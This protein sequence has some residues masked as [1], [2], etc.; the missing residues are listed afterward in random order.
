MKQLRWFAFI[1]ILCSGCTTTYSPSKD[2]PASLRIHGERRGAFDWDA[3]SLLTIDQKPV[4]MT[5]SASS[6]RKIDAGQHRL[7]LHYEGNRQLFGYHLSAPPIVVI[8]NFELGKKYDLKGEFKDT[9]VTVFVVDAG[10]GSLVSERVSAPV[11]YYS[12]V[13]PTPIVVP[14]QTR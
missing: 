5:W 6:P 2:N 7:V 9:E 13:S 14:V 3:L 8:A 4:S 1:V 12:P 10:S 11:G